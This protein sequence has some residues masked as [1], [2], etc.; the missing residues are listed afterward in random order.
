MTLYRQVAESL[1]QDIREGIYEEGEKVP[2]VRG[3]SKR[4]SVSISTITQAYAILEDQGLIQS[5]PQS[6]Y[7]VREGANDDLPV[8]PLS[9]GSQ[10]EE[11]TKVELISNVLKSSSQPGLI[12]LGAAIPDISLLPLRA[13]QNHVQKVARFN[14]SE[15]FNYQFA[16]GL[17]S[18]RQQIAKRMR[19]IKVRCHPD[20][21][22]ITNGA[23]EAIFLSLS[24]VCQAGDII[25]VE[26][27]CYYG[28]LQMAQR[29]GLKVIEIPTDPASGISLEALQLALN[30]WSIKAICLSSRFS[31]PSSA[32][33]STDKQQAF[34]QL[35]Q[36][37]PELTVIEDDIYGEPGF[38]D[39]INTVLKTFDETQQVIHCS[40]FSK[41]IAPGLHI[42]WCIP[43]KH[44]QNVK[45][46]QMFST[47]SASSL[48]QHA[49]SSYLEQGNYDKHL[50]K[51]V[52][53]FKDNVELFSNLIRLHFPEGT[54]LSVPAGGFILWVCLPAKVKALELQALAEKESISIVPGDI[55]TTQN[56]FSNYIRINCALPKD[57]S[58]K[59]AIIRL[60]QL[61]QQLQ[62]A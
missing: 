59:Q 58:I 47:L 37:Y 3:L 1:A 4:L 51:M 44:Y 18:L 42:G 24:S 16:P 49:M 13:I 35:V 57:D 15:A 43:G 11:V 54:K 34:M 32:S 50:R 27:P 62:T 10:P 48:S 23:T 29:Q 39:D 52:Q 45:E 25:A 55:F 30:Q 46:G 53:I 26:S 56:Q 17:E 8:P 41:G 61:A 21:I 9:Q 31:N 5:R 7:Y 22:I 2:S 38:N 19:H 36:Q 28:Y 60:G 40:S 20:D 33:I 14:S 6:G 12:R